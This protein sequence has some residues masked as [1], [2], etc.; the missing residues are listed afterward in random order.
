MNNFSTNE[1]KKIIKNAQF[2]GSENSFSKISTL[3]EADPN[4]IIWISPKKE[5]KESLINNSKANVIVCDIDVDES[6]IDTQKTIIKVQDPRLTF[7]RI[8][9]NYFEEKEIPSIHNS[10]IISKN[11]VIGKNVSIGPNTCIENV[12][13]GDNTIIH[14][15]CYIYSKTTIGNNVVIQA[16]TVIGSDGFGYEKNEDGVWEKFPHL[17]GVVIEDF[18]EI[19]SNASIDKGTIGNTIIKKGAKIDNLV[20]IAHNVEIGENSMIIA[21]AMIGGSTIIQNNVW[22]AP[23]S[24]IREGICI[25]NNSLVGL[26]AVVTKNIPENQIWIGNPAKELVKKNE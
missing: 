22:V 25:G 15:N 6:L 17:G 8:C 19:G 7:L 23:S 14:G 1:L 5:N 11:A 20:H 9:K 3:N 2:Y 24:A 12:I 21:N 26:G 10:A 18:V 4:S 13:I 16:N